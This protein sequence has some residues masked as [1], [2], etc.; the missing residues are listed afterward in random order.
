MIGESDMKL[1]IKHIIND[2]GPEGE[3]WLA[4]AVEAGDG[5]DKTRENAARERQQAPDQI[6]DT[7][8]A[9]G[10]VEAGK[11]PAATPEMPGP[12]ETAVSDDNIYNEA[13]YSDGQGSAPDSVAEYAENEEHDGSAARNEK[14]PDS[15]VQA[16]GEGGTSQLADAYEVLHRL[17]ALDDALKNTER[18]AEAP[19]AYDIPA[20][21]GGQEPPR[22]HDPQVSY[23]GPEDPVHEQHGGG[24]GRGK[25]VWIAAIAAAFIVLLAVTYI[26]TAM[27]PR[28]VNATINDEPV[29]I[30]TKAHTVGKLLE[31]QGID[32]CDDDYISV[33][34]TTYVS[35]GLTFELKHAVDFKVTADGKT[36]NFRTLYETVGEALS[37]CGVKVGK[38]DIVEPSVD[39]LMSDG[40]DIVVKR[41]RIEKKTVVEKVAFKTVTKEDSSLD[42]GKTK[43]VKKGRKGKAKITYRIKYIDGKVA[44]KKKI[45]KKIIRKPVNKVVAEGTRFVFD[46]SSYSRKLTV[47]AYAYTG[48]GRTAMGT[49]ARVGE[50][51]VDPS[52]I[53]LGTTV[54]IEGVGERRAEDTG[55]N[56][57]GNTIDIYMNSEAECRSWGV[58]YITIYIK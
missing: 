23:E 20:D 31:E 33:P 49:Q 34:L 58:R 13:V 3:H 28:D 26:Y 50:I 43:V 51:A 44:S 52:V 47:K 46:G 9:S 29:A 41:V 11:A 6:A 21:D 39:T 4:D 10:S 24:G 8:A 19:E 55:G 30:T 40:M 48:G 32:Y 57:K 7:E 17:Q 37:D 5:G 15:P 38:L 53:P 1:D 35:E 27:I 14:T 18:E 2:P 36:K 22:P 45:S 25:Y 56:I 16:S 54:Y 12:D 42:Q